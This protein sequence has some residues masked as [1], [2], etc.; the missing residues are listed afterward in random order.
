MRSRERRTAQRAYGPTPL[1]E[2]PTLPDITQDAVVVVPGIMGSALYDR[3]DQR[4]VWG[5]RDPR[6][7][8]SPARSEPN[9]LRLDDADR[10]G[11][12]VRLRPDGLLRVA[13][14]MPLLKGLEP[15]RE[16]TRAVGSVVAGPAA[17]LE[18]AYDWRL[19]VTVNGRLL[20]REARRHLETWR[21]TRAHDDARRVRAD[22]RPARLV[23]VAHS[24]GGLV[25]RAALA[26][27]PDLA[28]DTR[29]VIT[30]GTPFYGSV[31]AA[32]ILNGDRGAALP[33]GA[34]AWL[35]RRLAH[36]ARG[37]PGVHDL[38]P[39]YRCVDEGDDAR[40]LT[41][42][43]VGAL[44]GDPG[45]ADEAARRWER[46]HGVPLP[47]HHA[48][49]GVAQPTPQ[50]M[51]LSGGQVRPQYQA[52]EAHGDGELVRTADGMPARRARHGDGTV[53]RDAATLGGPAVHSVPGQHGAL[54][55]NNAVLADIRAALTAPDEGL[56][57]PMGDPHVGL[58]VPDAAAAN[59][60]WW[61]RLVGETALGSDVG[62][63]VEDATTG[64]PVARP[65]PQWRDDVLAAPVTLPEPGLYRV[66]ADTGGAA[67]LTQ[68][69]LATDPDADA[70]GRST[71]G[72]GE[73][74]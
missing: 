69:V 6:A 30:V 42:A 59:S 71:T 53:Y 10:E 60:R 16:L 18:F 23:F 39:A 54:V 66:V 27:A 67:P 51:S 26:H 12:A 49:V 72:A 74:A 58:D 7:L 3:V 34:P 47:G 64:R 36:L 14:W 48:V 2:Q 70:P 73:P 28:L 55:A 13:G 29:A 44:G 62:L 46:L 65:L 41:A 68:L 33:G 50:A 9:P 24:M 43:D 45:L 19:S 21:G 63:L 17:L 57:P 25:T 52:F 31:K 1:Q 8:W 22:E 40:R 32:Q 38:L 15:Y 56:G 20:A 61:L 37:L 11:A 35:L 5:L 4:L